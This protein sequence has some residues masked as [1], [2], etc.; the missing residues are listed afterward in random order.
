M[1]A[2]DSH[3]APRWLRLAGLLPAA[4]LLASCSVTPPS[5]AVPAD[6]SVPTAAMEARLLPVTA[7][8]TAPAADPSLGPAVVLSPNRVVSVQAEEP[9]YAPPESMKLWRGGKP[10]PGQKSAPAAAAERTAVPGAL[11]KNA[12]ALEA[13]PIAIAS[14]PTV[15][16]VDATGE[17]PRYALPETL[18]HWHGTRTAPLYADPNVEQWQAAPTEARLKNA[19]VSCNYKDEGGVRGKVML[20]VDDFKLTRFNARIEM[21]NGGV[22]QFDSKRMTQRPFDQGLALESKGDE[23][24][25]RMWEQKSRIT[26]AAYNC[27]RQCSKGSF[28]YLWPILMD[29]RLGT[30]Y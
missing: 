26:V 8:G 23:C 15:A 4:A 29:T 1:P 5:P 10:P 28:S 27:H 14:R 30:C 21:P 20:L 16:A 22:C 12:P 24:V 19:A 13:A 2:V 3:Y 9:R 7:S 18:S 11:P 25:V 17:E 6:D